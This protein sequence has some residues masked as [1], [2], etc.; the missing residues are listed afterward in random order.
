VSARRRWTTFVLAWLVSAVVSLFA[1]AVPFGNSPLMFWA[2]WFFFV[3]ATGFGGAVVTILAGTPQRR[4]LDAQFVVGA[5]ESAPGQHMQVSP[6]E[7]EE[8]LA[9]RRAGGGR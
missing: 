3:M 4:S 6:A 5:G 9:R 8:L 2:T 1:L 7:M